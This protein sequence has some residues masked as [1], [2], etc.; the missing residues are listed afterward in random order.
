MKQWWI[1]QQHAWRAAY[2]AARREPLAWLASVGVVATAVLLPVLLHLFI[3]WMVPAAREIAA[4]PEVS[5]Y[6]AVDATPGDYREAQALIEE[7]VNALRAAYASARVA[8]TLVPKAQALEQ[9][10]AQAE[11][12]GN[13]AAFAA[14]RDN[15]LPDGLVIRFN[16]VPA[17]EIDGF[18]QR[19]RAIPK[20]EAVQL[21]AQWVRR[22]AAAVRTASALQ[23]ALSALFALVVVA[24][25]FNATY[26]Q[27][28]AL[29]DEIEVARL[30]GATNATIRR[31][32]VVRG[33]VLGFAGAAL[34]LLLAAL[35]A[36]TGATLFDAAAAGAAAIS[37]T[38]VAIVSCAV[39]LL[40]G[41]GGW[42]S[43][44]RQLRRVGV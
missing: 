29:R 5:V 18:A 1:G 34:A 25:T 2:A 8:V 41:A 33:A 32:F 43:A 19:V 13:A 23:W 16:A 31:P 10:K 37:L 40:G 4:D 22:V 26:A 42:W 24:V 39:A 17:G 38:E 20:V 15:P 36:R 21:D 9:F 30:V 27:V 11:R 44:T 3:G 7:Q 28:L 14:L 12:A 35:I 6:L